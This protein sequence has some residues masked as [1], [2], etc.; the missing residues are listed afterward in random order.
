MSPIKT[1]VILVVSCTA[2]A[3]AQNGAAASAEPAQDQT[4]PARPQAV[5]VSTGMML[6]LVEHKTMPVYPEEAMKKGIQ[7]D[8]VF[9]VEVDE[10]GKIASS[11]AVEGDPLLVAAG[12]DSLQTFHFHPY[13]VN[14]TPTRMQGQLGFHFSTEKTA[15]GTSGHVECMASIPDR[16]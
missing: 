12:K 10:A 5:H 8:V 11:A 3:F 7:G 13:I 14:G 1:T 9:K 6:G 4:Q 15:D 2:I 16:P